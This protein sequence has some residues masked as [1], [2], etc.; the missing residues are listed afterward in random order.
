MKKILLMSA[1]MCQLA[2]LYA[3]EAAP[4]PP[5]S[6]SAPPTAADV[7]ALRQQVQSLTEAVKSLQQQVKDQQT[8]INNAKGGE[9]AL[10]QS[11]ETTPA[12]VAGNSPAAT[13]TAAPLFPTEDSSVVAAAPGKTP[14]STAPPITPDG[15]AVSGSFPTTD[16]SVVPA[17][18]SSATASTASSLTGPI[19][20]G[21]GKAYM[22]ISLDAMF[23]LAYSSASDLDHVE[24]GDHDPQQRGFNARNLELAFDGAVDPY[25][26]G[27][28]NIVF[29][30]DNDNETEVEVEE[31]FL[32]TTSL[33]FNLQVKAGQFFAA[34]GR[35]NPT[36]P[37]VWDFA[38]APLI[39]GRILGP[40]GLRGV[41]AQLSWTMPTP[42]YSQV[43]M[44]VQNGRGGT[45]FSFRNPGDNGIFFDRQTTDREIRG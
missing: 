33:P 22:N 40:D 17:A 4:S 12:P 5:A 38:D 9:P 27:F 44:G 29:K 8:M 11:P 15:T 35:I 39:L 43:L 26:Q 19:T 14:A 41:G 24:V 42:W 30:L 23:A 13:P 37:H 28:A 7:E 1:A 45:A 3:Q 32:Q 36:H 20:I 34:F 6:S 21:G 10:P 16:S 25:F 18:D 31:A 2:S